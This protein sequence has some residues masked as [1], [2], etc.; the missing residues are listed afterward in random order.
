MKQQPHSFVYTFKLI[1]ALIHLKLIG[2]SLGAELKS[3]HVPNVQQRE[4]VPR[5]KKTE[6]DTIE[7]NDIKEEV[8]L[9]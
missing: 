1:I 2:L 3:M 9:L 7:Q 4:P 8:V 5:R 6:L